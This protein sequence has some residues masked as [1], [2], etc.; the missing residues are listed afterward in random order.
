MRPSEPKV[1]TAIAMI[2]KGLAAAAGPG[3][4]V[5]LSGC[6]DAGR[7]T[8]VLRKSLSPQYTRLSMVA[9]RRPHL[10]GPFEETIH[11]V[12][13]GARVPSSGGELQR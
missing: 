13:Q 7:S 11:I 1:A 4:G 5:C 2:L 10:A 3:C 8:K 9:R 12:S 6:I